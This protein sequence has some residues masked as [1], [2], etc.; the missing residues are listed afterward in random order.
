LPAASPAAAPSGRGRPAAWPSIRRA[1]WHRSLVWPHVPAPPWPMPRPAKRTGDPLWTIGRVDP[2][3]SAEGDA[4]VLESLQGRRFLACAHITRRFGHHHPSVRGRRGRS[5][6][7][8]CPGTD[9]RRVVGLAYLTRR[10][11]T[12]P[13]SP[14]ALQS[15]QSDPERGGDEHRCQDGYREHQH[16]ALLVNPML[17]IHSR[18]LLHL[19]EP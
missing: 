9:A 3:G 2:H 13:Y 8:A 16:N 14:P 15:V 11:D 19:D 18:P 12:W 5:S 1:H 10:G 6:G 4:G 7:M 17:K